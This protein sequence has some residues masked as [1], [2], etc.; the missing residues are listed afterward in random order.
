MESGEK[1]YIKVTQMIKKGEIRNEN[2]CLVVKKVYFIH[3]IAGMTHKDWTSDPWRILHIETF[4]SV[5]QT[6]Q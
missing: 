3:R 1:F 4:W 6:S 2:I 5:Y